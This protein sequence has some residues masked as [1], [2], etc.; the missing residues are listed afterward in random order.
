MWVLLLISFAMVTIDFKTIQGSVFQQENDHCQK[1]S[2]YNE[3]KSDIPD[4]LP[5]TGIYSSFPLQNTKLQWCL[6]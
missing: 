1:A 3:A 4:F 5:K 2:D 6:Q